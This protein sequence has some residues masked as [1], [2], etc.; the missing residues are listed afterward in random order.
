[1]KNPVQVIQPAVEKIF[2]VNQ[3]LLGPKMG[4]GD[5]SLLR[6]FDFF[7][8]QI[9][10]NAAYCLH[11]LPAPSMLNSLFEKNKD[12]ATEHKEELLARM[13]KNM[14][15]YISKIDRLYTEYDIREGDALEEM[16]K[17][18]E[19]TKTDL[20][21]VGQQQKEKG[22]VIL[23]K[24]LIRQTKAHTLVIPENAKPQI[25]TILVPVDFSP[26]SAKAL[27]AAIKIHRQLQQP[28][29]IICLN[30]YSIPDLVHFRL[31][32]SWIQLKDMVEENIKIG[33]DAFLTSTAGEYREHIELALI[34]KEQTS[35]A[36][37]VLNYA[38]KNKVDFMAIG[39]KGHSRIHLLLMGSVT[40]EILDLNGEI[41]ILVVK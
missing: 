9:T 2:E 25:S 38:K 31:E 10:I 28:A 40:E 7:S 6:Y 18:A 39:A 15:R 20:V 11:V 4:A 33:F 22:I 13:E 16:V 29:R 3:A 36:P 26:S 8:Q 27:Q 19:T 30:V 35:V 32:G 24:N 34:E 5:A 14:E 12:A 1:M 41:P 17:E 23:T 21:V 37:Y